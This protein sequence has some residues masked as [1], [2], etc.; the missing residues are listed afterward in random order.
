MPFPEDDN[1][2]I[3]HCQPWGHFLYV[4][5]VMVVRWNATF[6]CSIVQCGAVPGRLV[7]DVL[8]SLPVRKGYLVSLAFDGVSGLDVARACCFDAK[9]G[10]SFACFK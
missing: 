3:R 2:F 7:C 8:V 1:L 5:A 6:R 4:I 9:R 10:V